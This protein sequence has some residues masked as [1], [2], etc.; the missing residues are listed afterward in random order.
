MDSICAIATANVANIAADEDSDL[1]VTDNLEE[2][3][4][5][6]KVQ[7]ALGVQNEQRAQSLFAK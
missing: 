4:V 6:R 5:V 7:A 1:D 2:I 3:L